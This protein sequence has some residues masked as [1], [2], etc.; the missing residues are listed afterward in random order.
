MDG[1]RVVSPCLKP[2]TWYLNGRSSIFDDDD[3]DFR[4]PIGAIEAQEMY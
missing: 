2:G 4:N 3:D 1:S